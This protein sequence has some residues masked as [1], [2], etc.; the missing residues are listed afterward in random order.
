V[1]YSR[2]R[3]AIIRDA[4]GMKLYLETLTVHRNRATPVGS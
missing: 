3:S 2:R 4:Y 1:G